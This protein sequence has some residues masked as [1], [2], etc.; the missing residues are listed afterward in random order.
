MPVWVLF[1]VLLSGA[2]A[3]AA[4]IWPIA[5]GRARGRTASDEWQPDPELAEGHRPPEL[6]ALATQLLGLVRQAVGGQGVALLRRAEAGWKVVA[7]SPGT[8]FVSGT[9]APL[10]E[11]LVGLAGEGDREIVA[12]PVH[13]EALR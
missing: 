9:P 10:K 13:A 1:L 4:A 11:G 3:G 12:D 6:G 5:R 8:S 7:T 2:L